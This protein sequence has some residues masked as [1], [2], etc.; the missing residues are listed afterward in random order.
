MPKRRSKTPDNPDLLK[1]FFEDVAR[2]PIINGKHDYL[3]LTRRIQRRV[4][5]DTCTEAT[6]Q[7]TFRK[8]LRELN[9][10]TNAF[11]QQCTFFRQHTLNTNALASEIDAFFDTPQQMTPP[12]LNRSL[13]KRLRLDDEERDRFED[14]GW[15]CFYLM[16]CLPAS[17]RALDP[18]Q[19]YSPEVLEHFS[20]IRAEAKAAKQRLMEGTLRY[21]INLARLY[22]T[23]KIPY[24]DL[25]QA[26]FLGLERAADR[27]NERRGHFQAYAGHWIKQQITRYIADHS[28][29]I[30]I[31]VHYIEQINQWREIY[32]RHLEANGGTLDY[33]QFCKEVGWL[34]ADDVQILQSSR[35]TSALAARE[36]NAILERERLLTALSKAYRNFTTFYLA[37]Q[38][39]LS[40]E[41]SPHW[42]PSIE[43]GLAATVGDFVVDEAA[44]QDLHHLDLP[45]TNLEAAL[46]KLSD[47]HRQ[48]ARLRYGMEDGQDHT[49]EEV[50]QI[51]GVTRERI[52]QIEELSLRRLANSSLSLATRDKYDEELSRTRCINSQLSAKL[53]RAIIAH[54]EI[55]VDD[56]LQIRQ[57]IRRIETLIEQYIPGGRKR[58]WQ[59]NRQSGRAEMF[60]QIL[61]EIGQPTHYGDLHLHAMKLVPEG[62]EFAK[63][64]TYTTLFYHRY[65][66]S[67]G[68]S[69][70]GLTEWETVT[71]APS[72]EQVLNHCPMPLLPAQTYPTAFFES[73]MVGAAYLKAG[74]TPARQFWAEMVAWAKQ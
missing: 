22:V 59:A 45:V 54:D 15:R 48:V 29:L 18:N 71:D 66:R 56:G 38:P 47:R 73:V 53:H 68:N 14:A 9:L 17:F 30:R 55:H 61:L 1:L 11:D 6:P 12:A 49:L 2:T 52:R 35:A 72:G 69:T 60:R 16:A 43:E 42:L 41:Q 24:L 64:A 57:E 39:V 13:G 8:L 37:T 51:I 32:N 74:P 23:D 70:F 28:T 65:F 21:A 26:G 58:N 4:M 33:W 20:S 25:V 27:Y 5:L 40:L 10:A 67:F 44:T 34:S 62:M 63:T 7:A 46:G 19:T 36:F 31:P 50:G 3:P